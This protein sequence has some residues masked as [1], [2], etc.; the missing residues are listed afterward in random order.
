[1]TKFS[2]IKH[3]NNMPMLLDS[4]PDFILKLHFPVHVALIL[5]NFLPIFN[6]IKKY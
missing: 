2:V 4:S 5:Q 1:M 3:L 6:L